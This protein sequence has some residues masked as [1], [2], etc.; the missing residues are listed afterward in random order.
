MIYR[1][2]P[3]TCLSKGLNGSRLLFVL[4]FEKGHVVFM[5]ISLIIYAKV[6]NLRYIFVCLGVCNQCCEFRVDI[7]RFKNSPTYGGGAVKMLPVA[8]LQ[9]I[10]CVVHLGS[11]LIRSYI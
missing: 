9:L 3:F 6:Q 8:F 11:D 5:L 10:F 1:R 2:Q 7:C 4:L